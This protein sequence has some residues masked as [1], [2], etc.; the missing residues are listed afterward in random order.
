[1]DNYYLSVS[2]AKRLADRNVLVCGTVRDK[3]GVPDQEF[4]DFSE[5]ESDHVKTV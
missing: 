2:L 4:F 3:R 5:K 1:M